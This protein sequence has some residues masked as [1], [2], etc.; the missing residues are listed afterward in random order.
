MAIYIP[1]LPNKNY[2]VNVHSNM[3]NI[4]VRKHRYC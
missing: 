1:D 4:S 3:Y 2:V